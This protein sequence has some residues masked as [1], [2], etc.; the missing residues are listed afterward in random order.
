[1]NID[2]ALDEAVAVYRETREQ[3]ADDDL[4][5]ML[6]LVDDQDRKMVM[7]LAVDGNPINYLQQILAELDPPPRIVVFQADGYQ[8]VPTD[9]YPH[10]ERYVGRLHELYAEG[11]PC[12]LDAL[13]ISAI[14]INGERRMSIHPYRFTDGGI[15][16]LEPKRAEGDNCDGRAFD[17]MYRGLKA[18]TN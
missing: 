7:A 4:V 12:V 3:Y 11:H 6:L 17:A 1:M 2:Q 14:D 16:W 15:E 10:A 5:A 13:T 8:F 9:E 18:S